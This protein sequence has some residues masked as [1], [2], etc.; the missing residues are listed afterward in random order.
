M[1][2]MRIPRCTSLSATLPLIAVF[3]SGELIASAQP[4]PGD[5]QQRPQQG[6]TRRGGGREDRGR[7]G[8]AQCQ[9][10][11]SNP[12]T[13]YRR[14]KGEVEEPGAAAD[15]WWLGRPTAASRGITAT[16]EQSSVARQS[17]DWCGSEQSAAG[18]VS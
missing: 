16:P 10:D 7:S 15:G 14:A 2:G 6:E 13:A 1:T 3:I 9:G 11:F 8:R 17:T 5:G 4:A 12:S 18:T